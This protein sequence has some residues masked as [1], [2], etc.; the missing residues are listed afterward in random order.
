MA[1]IQELSILT[2]EDYR[3]L[4]SQLRDEGRI[5]NLPKVRGNLIVQDVYDLEGEL[6]GSIVYN[7]CT[8]VGITITSD[9]RRTVLSGLEEDE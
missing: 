7:F 3:G 6:S 5:P 9:V 8:Q 2:R 1:E 4:V